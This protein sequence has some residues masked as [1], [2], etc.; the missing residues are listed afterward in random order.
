MFSSKSLIVSGLMFKSLIHF[1]SIFVYDVRV[2]LSSISILFV[3]HRPNTPVIIALKLWYFIIIFYI[4]C[5]L[6]FPPNP[7]TTYKTFYT[8]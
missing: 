7:S 8:N 4:I 3:V 2:H 1:E 5:K 6:S